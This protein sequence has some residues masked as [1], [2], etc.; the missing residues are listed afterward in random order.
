MATQPRIG[1]AGSQPAAQIL[2]DRS[3]LSGIDD[4]LDGIACRCPRA[5]VGSTAQRLDCDGLHAWFRERNVETVFHP[6]PVPLLRISAQLYNTLEQFRQLA[7]LLEQAW[8][9][10]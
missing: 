8:R 7:G 9:A 2:A 10:A 5:E 6:T 3:A 4:R 1:V